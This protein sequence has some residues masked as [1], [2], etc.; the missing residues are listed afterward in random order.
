VLA[1]YITRNLFGI[2]P[3]D[4]RLL[5]MHVICAKRTARRT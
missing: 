5:L 2:G 4:A 3:T 1:G